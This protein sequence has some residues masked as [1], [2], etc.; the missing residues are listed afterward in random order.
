MTST[1]S[2]RVGY[3]LDVLRSCSFAGRDDRLA[4]VAKLLVDNDFSSLEQLREAEHPQEWVGAEVLEIGELDF[5]AAL[6]SMKRPR[7]R[8]VFLLLHS[9]LSIISFWARPVGGEVIAE[10]QAGRVA[11][12]SGE[13]S[14]GDTS[15]GFGPRMAMRELRLSERSVAERKAWLEQAR[16]EAVLG[17]CPLSLKSVRSGLRAYIGF[18]GEWYA[19]LHRHPSVAYCC[20]QTNVSRA[21]NDTFLPSLTF[22]SGGVGCLG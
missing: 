2:T 5:L 18:V 14:H 4:V 22:Y 7:V 11:S 20:W 13:C 15:H 9:V 10:V 16:I 3:W 19:D 1:H 12:L 6:R 17:S 8:C 21:Q